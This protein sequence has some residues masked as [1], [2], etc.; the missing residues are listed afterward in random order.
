MNLTD[1]PTPRTNSRL[2]DIGET[3]GMDPHSY[4][5]WTEAD[6]TRQLEREAAA[7]RAVAEMYRSPKGGSTCLQIIIKAEKAFDALKSQLK[8]NP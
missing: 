7:W 6:F 2:Y 5:D 4:G 8:E 3:S 1:Y